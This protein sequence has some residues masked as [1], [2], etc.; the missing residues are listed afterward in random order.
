M[1]SDNV[2]QCRAAGRADPGPAAHVRAR[3][4]EFLQSDGF[5]CTGGKSAHLQ[6]TLV[7]RHYDRLADPG[8][9]AHLHGDLAAFVCGKDDIH[10]LLATFVATFDGPR[11]M[12]EERFE[13][14]LWRQLSL[15][16][17]IDRRHY[18]W[19]PSADA[20][21]ASNRFAFS[22]AEH[23]FFVVGLHRKSSRYSRRFDWPALVFNS[24]VQFERMKREGMYAHIQRE[25]RYRELAL[26]GSLNPNLAEFGERSEAAQ[27]AGRAV[28]PDW[29]CPFRPHVGAPEGNSDD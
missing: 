1:T 29:R 23:P 24:H 18:G 17:E 3:L 27:Y 14:L 15:L 22:V 25:V 26:Q 11:E 28:P 8:T 20:E 16:H 2:T 12:S 10:E 9:T 4:G 21:P 13:E 19:A 5:S 6:G 7:H